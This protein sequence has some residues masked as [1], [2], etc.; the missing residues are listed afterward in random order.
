VTAHAARSAIILGAG[1]TGLATAYY[2][3]QQGYRAILLDHPDWQDGFHCNGSDDAPMVF[4]RHQ[5]TWR[6]LRALEAEASSTDD[7]PLPIEF[8]LPHGRIAV[9]RSSHLPGALQ[10]MTS[11]FNFR[12]LGWHDR[13]KLFSHLEQIWEQAAALPSDLENRAADEWLADIGQSE[14]ARAFIWHPLAQWLTGNSL[15][16][17]SA[18]NF[19][20]LL[21]NLFLGRAM[22]A[23]VT[24]LSGSVEERFLAPL[25]RRVDRL[26]GEVRRIKH[27]PLLRFDA[28]G[29]AGLRMDDGTSLEAERYVAAVPLRS[30]PALLPERLVTRYAY[31]AHI[32][33]LRALDEAVVELICHSAARTPRLLLLADRPF[34]RLTVAAHGPHAIRCR[35]TITQ[36]AGSERPPDHHLAALGSDEL[37][38]LRPAI[39][40]C[41]IRSIA[42]TQHGPS[43]LSLHPGTARLR[44]IQQ[45]PC[46]NLLVAGP[47]T[48]TGWPPGVE[49][50]LVSAGKCAEAMTRTAA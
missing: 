13:L 34:H 37:A 18:A 17:L 12:G 19:V 50:A 25:R 42:V 35:L 48:D 7:H 6:L 28:A 4:G 1:L 49:S 32:G 14:Q 9:Y 36:E 5:D 20:H 46:V 40:P 44:P 2:L 24:A 43:A 33:E 8:L 10:W 26:G 27:Q 47:W 38:A 22:D 23:R 31:F 45:S 21:S 15:A 11:L 29:V 30:L 39:G 41:D 16:R 3:G